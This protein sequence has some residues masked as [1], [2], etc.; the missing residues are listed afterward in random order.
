MSTRDVGQH[1][2]QLALRY[3]RRKGYA[4]LCRNYRYGHYEIDLVMQDGDY[5]VFV[6]VKA[7]TDG[8]R[9]GTP[10]MAVGREKQRC[11]LLAA[12]GY[13]LEHGCAESPARFDVVEVYLAEGKIQ[14]I[15]HIV[16]A[17]WG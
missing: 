6:E 4:L 5:V 12:Q 14:H 17:F 16:N 7:R 8:E 1:G 11:L 3:L 2:E 10:A 9:F 15:E 13:L